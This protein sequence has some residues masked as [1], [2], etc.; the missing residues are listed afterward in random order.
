MNTPLVDPPASARSS[1]ARVPAATRVKRA[2]GRA[3]RNVRRFGGRAPRWL[4]V[5]LYVVV[6][7]FLVYLLAANVILRT[8]LLR[9]WVSGD[10]R[11]IK[12]E[13]S[14]A[15]SLYPGN[16][17]VR[18]L[19]LRFQSSD[20]QM[21]IL[22][23]R[24][25]VQIDLF[26]LTKRNFHVSKLDVE[27][28]TYRLR[29]KVESV[30]G[31]EER[32]RSF[33]DIAGFSDPPLKDPVP[34]PPGDESKNWSVDIPDISATLRD[35]WT[36]EFRYRGEG[37]LKGGFHVKRG[38]EVWVRPSMMLTHGG[39]YS[40]GTRDLVRGGEARLDAEM[41]P[42]DV[43]ETK[44]LAVLRHLTAAIHQ[45]G[46]LVFPSIGATYLPKGTG[47]ELT[48]GTG[49]AALDVRVDHGVFQPGTRVTFHTADLGLEAEAIAMETDLDLVAHVE[50]AEGKPTIIGE[51]SIA[52]ATGKPLEIR[53]A[54]GLVDVGNADLAAPFR[55]ARAS[56]AV[57]SAHSADLRAWQPFAPETLTFN[58]GSATVAARG[59]YH[60][61][62][63]NG[64]VDLAME[65]SRLSIGPFAFETSGKAWSNVVSEDLEKAVTFPGTAVDL[66][67]I[68]LRL[69]SGHTEGLWMR[70]RF[71]NAKLSTT[72]PG[73]FD[74]DIA[75]DSGPGDKTLELFTRMTSLP[76]VAADV[77]SGTQLVASTHLRVRPGLIAFTVMKSK[78]GPMESRGRVQKRTGEP[79]GGAFL[80]SVGPF[81]AGLDL[82][83]GGVSVRPLAG[84]GWLEEKLQKQ[85]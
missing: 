60:G 47:L 80:V 30:E 55:I 71:E 1:V 22:L 75:V 78:N 29:Q 24:A 69:K 73:G 25:T 84:G 33:P 40:L 74:T 50:E 2:L 36:M 48:R 37:S 76:D 59:E 63:L 15:W 46:E 11:K 49:P 12:L 9:D 52:H 43:K 20:V 35:V 23:E 16:V 58:G 54:R 21:L 13:Y 45:R 17:K 34:E 64:R 5:V 57:T 10:E 38:R 56:G 66:H 32:V 67:G 68:S 18:D 31:Q 27:G 65:K 42:F 82:T 61:G 77:A 41:G 26:A 6:G 70:S 72:A 39:L 4:R 85:P 62:A 44:G 14:S 83:G 51:A 7:T 3:V 19:S 8:H 53:G 79:V 81:H 28:I